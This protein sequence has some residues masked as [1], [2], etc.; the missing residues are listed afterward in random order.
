MQKVS[1]I[2]PIPAFIIWMIPSPKTDLLTNRRYLITN[3]PSRRNILLER[4]R[5]FGIG[6]DRYRPKVT[7]MTKNGAT[8]DGWMADILFLKHDSRILRQS[9]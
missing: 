6:A 8:M 1:L 4:E 2:L 5:R 9:Q 3:L 7:T